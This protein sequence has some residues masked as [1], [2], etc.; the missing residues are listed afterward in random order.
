VVCWHAVARRRR[1]QAEAETGKSKE[2]QREGTS[3]FKD[4]KRER[5]NRWCAADAR[6]HDDVVGLAARDREGNPC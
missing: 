1:A 4:K 5:E 6:S 3:S 2:K